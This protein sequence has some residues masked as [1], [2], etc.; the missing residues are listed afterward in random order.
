MWLARTGEQGYALADCIR[1]G[2]VA[3]RYSDV[4]DASSLSVPQIAE[5][6]RRA[7]TRVN[8]AGVARMLFEFVR[9]VRLGDIV[10]TPHQGNREVYFGEV[11]GGYRF[12]DP[13]P[14]PGFLHLR[15][16]A[17]WGSLSRDTDI[18]E[19]RLVDIDRPPSFYELADRTYWVDQ[20]LM[21]KATTKSVTPPTRSGRPPTGDGRGP[22]RRTETRSEV[23]TS[24]GLLKPVGI[25]ESG[26]CA[27]CR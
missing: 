13:S 16:V 3:L 24:C 25:I 14:V 6:V 12:A 19:D 15:D 18:G 2:V 4:P 11:A 23:C 21:A 17:W 26:V 5:G 10:V 27:D 1:E 7:G 22:G 8:L 9:S 20:A